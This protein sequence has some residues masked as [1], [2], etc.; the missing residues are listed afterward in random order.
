MVPSTGEHL[1][2]ETTTTTAARRLKRASTRQW[3]LSATTVVLP[4]TTQRDCYTGLLLH[5][6]SPYLAAHLGPALSSR[7]AEVVMV[8]VVLVASLTMALPIFLPTIVPME[9]AYA[10]YLLYLPALYCVMLLDLR[11]LQTLWWQFDT[12]FLMGNWTILLFCC[13]GEWR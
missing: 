12:V 4:K 5:S 3:L 9:A 6:L 2:L 8:A 13:M 11:V 1:P 10:A 7:P